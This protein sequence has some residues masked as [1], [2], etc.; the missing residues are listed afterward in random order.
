M[1]NMTANEIIRFRIFSYTN[2]DR[3]KNWAMYRA[4]NKVKDDSLVG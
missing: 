4:G 2:Y 3:L 1:Y